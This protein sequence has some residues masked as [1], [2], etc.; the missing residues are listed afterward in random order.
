[1]KPLPQYKPKTLPPTDS[2]IMKWKGKRISPIYQKG[3]RNGGKEF[4]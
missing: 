1:M 4:E 2:L 3:D